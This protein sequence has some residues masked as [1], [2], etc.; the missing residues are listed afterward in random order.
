M[1]NYA[2]KGG[3]KTKQADKNTHKHV[4]LTQLVLTALNTQEDG[5][6]LGHVIN[7]STPVCFWISCFGSLYGKMNHEQVSKV[8]CVC[9]LCVKQL[10]THCLHGCK[11]ISPSTEMAQS[12]SLFFC[13]LGHV[14]IYCTM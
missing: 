6:M 8:I 12:M 5:V 1:H 13:T 14:D 11:R 4:S 7:P 3:K 9:F 10:E 2:G